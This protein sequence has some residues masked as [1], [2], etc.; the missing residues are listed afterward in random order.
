L[1][2]YH[3]MSNDHYSYIWQREDWPNWRYDKNA[4]EALVAAVQCGQKRLFDRLSSEGVLLHE[5]VN[6]AALSEDVLKTSEIEGERLNPASVRSSI[7]RRLGLDIGALA[8]VDRHVEGVVEMMLDATGNCHAPVT[9]ER[10]FGWHAALFSTGWS[11]L[12]RIKVGGFR[13]DAAGVMQVVSGPVG[14]QK[15]HFQAPPSDRLPFEMAR[16]LEWVNTSVAE[17]PLIKAGIGHLW[18]VTVHPFEDGNGR[19]ARAIGDLLLSRADGVSQRCYSVSAQIQ[20]QR[21]TYYRILEQSQKGSMDVTAWLA[22]FLKTLEA[23]IQQANS[24][25]DDVLRKNRFWQR[26]LPNSFNERQIKVL[27]RLL[28]GFEG[29]LTCRKWSSLAK[30]STETAQRDIDDLLNCNVLVEKTSN[31]RQGISYKLISY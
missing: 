29:K 14:R 13:D 17:P 3:P 22:W 24:M 1:L 5:Q 23:A 8:P 7:A 21:Q 19:I 4:L 18:F 10:L 25:L 27:N 11:G 15:V 12:S 2:Q 31:S 30:C 20:Q 28:D 9:E 16:F 6:L 26:F